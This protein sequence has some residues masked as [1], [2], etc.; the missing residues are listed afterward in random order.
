MA[1]LVNGSP[2][3]APFVIMLGQRWWVDWETGKCAR[4][5]PKVEDGEKEAAGPPPYE[6]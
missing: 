6:P 3:K 4:W 1:T 2:R 5:V